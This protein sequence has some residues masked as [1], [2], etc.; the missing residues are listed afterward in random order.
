MSEG[1]FINKNTCLAAIADTLYKLPFFTIHISIEQ[2]KHLQIGRTVEGQWEYESIKGIIEEIS[3]YPNPQTGKYSVRITWNQL[4][5][6]P[7]HPLH[8]K[9]KRKN[10]PT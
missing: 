6:N 2:T 4:D 9:N 8:R 5:L 3:K 10:T 7:L 1:T